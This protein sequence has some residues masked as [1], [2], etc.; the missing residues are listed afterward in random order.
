VLSPIIFF[1]LYI[2][3]YIYIYIYGG[4]ESHIAAKL[5]G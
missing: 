5:M 3:I 1:F 2:Y 4:E